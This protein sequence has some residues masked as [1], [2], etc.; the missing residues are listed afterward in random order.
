MNGWVIF[1]IVFFISVVAIISTI[2]SKL[3]I[4]TKEKVQEFQEEQERQRLE[5][6]RLRR[7]QC[8]AA[9]KQRKEAEAARQKR[10]ALRQKKEAMAKEVAEKFDDEVKILIGQ[11]LTKA[12]KKQIDDDDKMRINVYQGI[13]DAREKER[14]SI[15]K[16]KQA[17]VEKQK[18]LEEKL[19]LQSQR[20]KALEEQVRMRKEAREETLRMRKEARQAQMSNQKARQEIIR[21]VQAAKKQALMAAEKTKREALRGFSSGTVSSVDSDYSKIIFQ[22][23]FKDTLSKDLENIIK[24]HIR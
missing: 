10:E 5:Y 6:E 13:L 17:E 11:L 15:E 1:G 8:E 22:N 21:Q 19:K 20:K 23:K 4:G 9:N 24:K 12:S 3:L 7:E 18:R 2:I 16:A 14:V